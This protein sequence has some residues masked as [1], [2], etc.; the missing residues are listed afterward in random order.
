MKRLAFLAVVGA[1]VLG[2]PLLWGHLAANEDERYQRSRSL[3]PIVKNTP[4]VLP[5]SVSPGEVET[6]E[7]TPVLPRSSDA[8]AR[9]DIAERVG[10]LRSA[11]HARDGAL[12]SLH[13]RVVDVLIAITPS[14]SGSIAV[15]V[16]ELATELESGG[17]SR[18]IAALL[19]FAVAASGGEDAI[20]ANWA[21]IGR[22]GIPVLP[23]TIHGLRFDLDTAVKEPRRT[24]E[25][26]VAGIMLTRDCPFCLDWRRAFLRERLGDRYP[27]DTPRG[28]SGD[29][30]LEQLDLHLRAA[31][32]KRLTRSVGDSVFEATHEFV[33]ADHREPN[34]AAPILNSL[35]LYQRTNPA[36]KRRLVDIAVN[37]RTKAARLLALRQLSHPLEPDLQQRLLESAGDEHD[38]DVLPVLV[39]ALR[40][41][42]TRPGPLLS[43]LFHRGDNRETRRAVGRIAANV[44][45][46][47]TDPVLVAVFRHITT[48]KDGVLLVDVLGRLERRDLLQRRES[49]MLDAIAA[50]LQSADDV[51]VL[52]LLEIIRVHRIRELEESVMQLAS[53]TK[54][55]DV[56]A[57]A[58]DSLREMRG[59]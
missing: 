21:L 10:E 57:A 37:A 27:G 30:P 51:I 23:F 39:D 46:D 40:L 7:A 28:T 32:A 3:R 36:V 58:R 19:A 8:S 5:P 35:H 25:D 22:S 6:A 45:E 53:T 9:T 33:L 12:G 14:T 50:T 26:V 15:L 1:V 44:A 16:Q 24:L 29:S 20:M 54:S 11:F 38:A 56:A 13:K 43:E 2:T 31:A 47:A 52:R 42:G 4:E 17:G 55:S 49:S 18:E 59:G 41:T 48:A 34:Q